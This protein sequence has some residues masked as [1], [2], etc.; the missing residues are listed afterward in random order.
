MTTMEAIRA[1]HSTRAFSDRQVPLEDVRELLFAGA[2]AA[3][4]CA[5]FAGLKLYAVRNPELLAEIDKSAA[6]ANPSSHPLYGAPTLIVLAAKK[7]FLENIEYA[8]AGCVIQN[9]MVAAADKG[10]QSVYLWMGMNG[11]N[12]DPAIGAKLGFPEGYF[13]V[14]TC[15]LG[16]EANPFPKLRGDEQR[17]DAFI[18]D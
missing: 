12:A 5:D 17:V 11:V 9:I 3:I 2:Q 6:G 1:R 14:G 10:I 16:Y 4:G 7:G 18:L 8:N 13:C 15:A